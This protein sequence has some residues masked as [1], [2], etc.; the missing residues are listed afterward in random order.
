MKRNLRYLLL[1]SGRMGEA[2]GHDLLKQP[3]TALVTFADA[4]RARLAA[5]A[6]RFGPRRAAFVPCD[7]RD[8]ARLFPLMKRHDAVVSAV[9]YFLNLPLAR[10]AVGAGAHFC[11]LGGN[12]TI[13]RKQL[14]LDRTAARAGVTVVPDCGLAPGMANLLAAAAIESMDSADT[15]RIRVGGLP[16]DPVPPWN[17][18]QVFSVHGLL[19]EYLEHARVLRR[20][21]VVMVASLTGLETLRWPGIGKLEAFVTSGGTSTLPDT[22]AGRVRELDYKTIRFPGHCR[23]IRTFRDLGLTDTCRTLLDG[24]EHAPRELLG[25]ILR[26]AIPDTGPDQVLVRVVVRGRRKGR[27][28]TSET[29]LHDRHD[30]HTG[31]SAMMRTTGFPLAIVA[32]TLASGRARRSGA[33]PQERALDPAGFAAEC[34]KRGLAVRTRMS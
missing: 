34:R 28:V 9:P 33:L 31:F 17:Y 26:R 23:L 10:L 8:T 30:P 24:K 2:A 1:G 27:R 22:Y 14:S 16:R 4:D 21:R 7:A 13:V 3:D 25:E 20:G 5:L 6:R 12:D 19:N 29:V 18:R 11:D 15:V 32:R